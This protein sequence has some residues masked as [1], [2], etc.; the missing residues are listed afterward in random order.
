MTLILL[1][2]AFQV[3]HSDSARITLLAEIALA[4]AMPMA[5]SGLVYFHRALTL[6]DSALVSKPSN[7]YL[8]FAR[9]NLLNYIAAYH[10]SKGEISKGLGLLREALTIREVDQ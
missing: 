4:F 6:T 7:R 2:G 10:V 1:K 5:D 8:R 3:A 9:S